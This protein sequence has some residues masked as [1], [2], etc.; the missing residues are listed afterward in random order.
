MPIKP[1]PEVV[2]LINDQTRRKSFVALKDCHVRPAEIRPAF[3]A[4]I[5]GVMGGVGTPEPVVQRIAAEVA[6]IV[7]E[8][9]GI[10]QFGKA[11]IEPVGVGPVESRAALA[12]EAERLRKVVQDAGLKPQ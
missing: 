12:A 2:A 3:A 11:G 10:A 8:P 5:H 6:A 9:W 4:L 7:K 1:T